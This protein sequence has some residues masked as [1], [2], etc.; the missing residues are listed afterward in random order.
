MEGAK[1]MMREDHCRKLEQQLAAWK[2]NIEM[3]MTLA[4]K[5]PSTDPVADARQKENLR[6]VMQGIANVRKLLREQCT[7]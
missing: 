6:E 4:E 2:S 3:L 7:D 1:R 5:L